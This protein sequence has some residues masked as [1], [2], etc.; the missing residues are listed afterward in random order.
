MLNE[1]KSHAHKNAELPGSKYTDN[2]FM[3]NATI[4]NDA[5]NDSDEVKANLLHLNILKL[6]KP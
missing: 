4:R 1:H 3:L 5:I 6:L 2:V